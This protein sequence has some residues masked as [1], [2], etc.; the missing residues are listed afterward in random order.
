MTIVTKDRALALAMLLLAA[1]LL[2]ESGNIPG[3]TAWQP[4][5]SALY[6]RILLGV[7]GVL[8]TIILIRSFFS[9][10]AKSTSTR[11]SF[12]AYLVHNQKVLLL[13]VLFA[14]YA[15][16]LPVV[17]YLVATLGFLVLSLA[18]LLGVD[19]RRKV[20]VNLATSFTLAPLIYVIFRYGLRIWL[21]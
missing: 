3:K 15:A 4:Y 20:I 16:L 9:R 6:P 18:L 7:I 21:P 10:A 14:C 2:V 8:S 12:R 5:G 13:F 19:S 1:I 17:G 11:R